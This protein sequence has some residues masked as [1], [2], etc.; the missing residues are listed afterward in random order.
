[1][2]YEF[3]INCFPTD[4]DAIKF[5]NSNRAVKKISVDELEQLLTP[6][7]IPAPSSGDSKVAISK[8]QL[9]GMRKDMG[10]ALQREIMYDKALRNLCHLKKWKDAHGKDNH[11]EQ[12]QPEA[13]AY[14]FSII[15]QFSPHPD[16]A[17]PA[18]SSPEGS[19]EDASRNKV[20]LSNITEQTGIEL[21]WLLIWEQIEIWYGDIKKKETGK[22]FLL[23]LQKQY[24]LASHS[25]NSEY[26][27]RRC[28]AAEKTLDY[29][30]YDYDSFNEDEF[31]EYSKDREEWQAIKQSPVPAATNDSQPIRTA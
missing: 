21:G 23:R 31:Q 9:D 6:R 25:G 26:W 13:W 20:Q 16:Y 5:P 24:P 3:Y 27:Q 8:S 2:T 10:M 18:A 17:P 4:M 28:E 12:F 7:S 14:A 29:L 22:D 15:N 1:M 30:T 11:Y 19:K